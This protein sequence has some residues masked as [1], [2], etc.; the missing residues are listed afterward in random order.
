MR[1]GREIDA[2]IAKEVFGYNVWA[3]N[4]QLF[5]NAE[6]GDRPLRNYSKEVEWAMEVAKKMK[7]ALLPVS[8][9][10]W[11][12]FIGPDTADGWESPQAM[13]KFLEAGNFNECGA[14]V[15]ENPAAIIC[16]A[17]LKA[18]EKRRQA[19]SEVQPVHADLHV[20]PADDAENMH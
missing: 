4:K 6:K 18:T 17:A 15:G 20:V 19:Q 1:P 2:R 12:A 3:Q 9:G 16:E 13:L 14:A 10:Q 11:F 7:I 8:G 5:E